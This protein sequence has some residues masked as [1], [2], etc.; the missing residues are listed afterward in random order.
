MDKGYEQIMK[1]ELKDASSLKE[2]FDVLGKYYELENCKPG[3]ITK[4]ILISKLEEAVKY[5]K[6]APRKQY[7]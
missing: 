3:F 1:Q 6:A 7:T 2:C 5:M 4:G